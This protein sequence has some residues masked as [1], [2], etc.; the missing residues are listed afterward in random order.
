MTAPQ[1]PK[2]EPATVSTSFRVPAGLK[3]EYM[4][5]AGSTGRTRNKLYTEALETY[6]ALLRSGLT[7][8]PDPQLAELRPKYA[9]GLAERPNYPRPNGPR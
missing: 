2:S 8:A 4:I 3:A 6:A 1:K 7:V 9:G 5:L